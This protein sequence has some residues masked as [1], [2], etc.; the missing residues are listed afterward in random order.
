MN[1]VLVGLSLILIPSGAVTL[2][3][4]PGRV[5]G[6]DTRIAGLLI[7]IAG[8]VALLTTLVFFASFAPFGRARRRRKSETRAELDPP[9]ARTK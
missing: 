9:W 4:V 1:D 2:W 7:L 3:A 6:V 8:V 5:L